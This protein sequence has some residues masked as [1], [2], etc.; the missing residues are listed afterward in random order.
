[1]LVDVSNVLQLI[2]VEDRGWRGLLVA[3]LHTHL[4]NILADLAIIA[5]ADTA[6]MCSLSTFQEWCTS[7]GRRQ[8]WWWSITSSSEVPWNIEKAQIKKAAPAAL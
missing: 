5:A 6:T 7:T 8:C 3:R 4:L 2:H 1:M